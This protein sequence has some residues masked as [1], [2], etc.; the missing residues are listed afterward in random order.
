MIPQG[1]ACNNV[2]GLEFS[3][4]FYLVSYVLIVELLAQEEV[5]K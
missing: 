5:L 3:L 4:E 2:Y 1:A